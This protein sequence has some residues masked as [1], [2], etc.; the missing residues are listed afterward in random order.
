MR[1]YRSPAPF[2][3][4]NQGATLNGVKRL[5]ESTGLALMRG[6]GLS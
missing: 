6:H 1:I 2:P 3:A 4:V 5:Q